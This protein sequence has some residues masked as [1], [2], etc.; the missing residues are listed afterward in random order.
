MIDGR[1]EHRDS[2]GG[3]GVIGPGEIQYMSA[4]TGIVHSEFNASETA[5]CHLLQIWIMPDVAG[6]TPSYGQKDFDDGRL[7]GAL[8]LVASSDGAEDSIAIHQD[9]RVHAGRLNA[10]QTVEHSLGEGRLAWLQVA[11]GSVGC[12][13]ETLEQGDGLAVRDVP[14]LDIA[15]R[16]DCEVLLFDMAA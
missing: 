10:G 8:G 12:L 2:T 9:A 3:G 16:E 7:D 11:R 15:G 13:G 1:L 4:G 6:A 5:S 14:L